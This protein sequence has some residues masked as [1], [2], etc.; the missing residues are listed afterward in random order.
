VAWD[1]LGTYLSL[2]NIKPVNVLLFNYWTMGA[3]RHGDYIAKVRLTPP[4]AAADQV[5]RRLL[6]TA[7][8]PDVFRPA[9]VDELRERPYE[10]D[11]Q[12]QLCT[13][14]ERMPVEDLTMEWPEALSPFVTVAKVRLPRQN[15]GVTRGVARVTKSVTCSRHG[16][17]LP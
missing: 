7:S 2:K 12:V 3:V 8:A 16:S 17:Q 1:E 5:V 13:D 10:F 6:D 11:L 15:K 4:R 9:L 14:L